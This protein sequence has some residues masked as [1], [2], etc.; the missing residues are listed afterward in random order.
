MAEFEAFDPS[1]EEGTPPRS[2]LPAG[3]YP[4]EIV[5]AT[6]ATTKNQKG[7]M[8]NLTWQINQPGFEHRHVYQSIL[9]R[10]ESAEA[11][12]FGRYKLKDLCVACGITSTVTDL[13]E[14]YFKPC[15]ITVGIEKDK[16]GV[17][18]DKNKVTRILP[19]AKAAV[20]PPRTIDTSAPSHQ[21]SPEDK[22]APF[23][24]TVPF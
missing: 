18:P 23:N 20:P 8:L 10:H 11:E 15:L 3:K 16:D 19:L 6:V 1:K 17:Y 24:D 2:L 4:A 12:R 14:F 21:A 22:A 7:T 5:D 9:T 13:G